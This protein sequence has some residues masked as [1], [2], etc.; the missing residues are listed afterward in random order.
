VCVQIPFEF[1][2][3]WCSQNIEVSEILSR[4]DILPTVA[5]ERQIIKGV[6]VFRCVCV[7]VCLC[8][9]VC[10][11]VCVTLFVCVCVRT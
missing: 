9:R 5:E 3:K 8:V 4:F 2:A 1:F 6:C 7:C 10:A 11:C